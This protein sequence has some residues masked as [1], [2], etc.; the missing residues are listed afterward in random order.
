MTN[1]IKSISS[2]TLRDNL[3]DTL[4]E[5]EKNKNQLLVI[6]RHGDSEAALINLD[7]LESVLDVLDKKL[8]AKLHQA[9]LQANRGEVISFAEA[10]GEL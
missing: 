4:D 8:M 9:R 6:E 5:V 7:V 10:F 1:S 3:S 2:S